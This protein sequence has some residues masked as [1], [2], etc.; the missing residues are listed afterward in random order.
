MDIQTNGRFRQVQC[1]VSE[2]WEESNSGEVYS[3]VKLLAE[4]VNNNTKETRNI[5]RWLLLVVSVIALAEKLPQAVEALEK[6]K[7]FL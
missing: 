6:L 3:S 5:T 2:R 1:P 7:H 4:A